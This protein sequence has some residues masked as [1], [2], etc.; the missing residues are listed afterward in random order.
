MPVESFDGYVWQALCNG[1][2]PSHSHESETGGHDQRRFGQV[3][4]HKVF[5]W[6]LK[7][8]RLYHSRLAIAGFWS[9]EAA[10]ALNLIWQEDLLTNNRW[11]LKT[12]H[13]SKDLPIS[14]NQIVYATHIVSLID[15]NP[16]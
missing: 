9:V 8:L 14:S 2:T 4:G 1:G 15:L 6:S 13:L 3:E 7:P 12:H 11:L 16:V 5:D 10:N